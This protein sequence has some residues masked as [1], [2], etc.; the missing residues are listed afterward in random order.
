MKIGFSILSLFLILLSPRAQAQMFSCETTYMESCVGPKAHLKTAIESCELEMKAA[1]CDEWFKDRPQASGAKRTCDPIEVCPMPAKIT[2]LAESCADGVWNSSVDLVKGA[3]D[4]VV[5]S[6]K[7]SPEVKAREDYFKKCVSPECKIEMLG[8]YADLFTLE[9]IAGTKDTK[10]NP[11]DVQ[12][13]VYLNG[14]SSK[15]LYRMLQEKLR[16][17]AQNGNSSDLWIEPWSGNPAAPKRSVDDLVQEVMTASGM[18]NTA[19]YRPEKVYEARCYALASVLDPLAASVAILRIKK[20]SGLLHAT[21][22]KRIAK[23]VKRDEHVANNVMRGSTIDVEEFKKSTAGIWADKNLTDQ[24][25]AQAVF[26]K[27]YEMRT[28]NLDSYL[29]GHADKVIGDVQYVKGSKGQYNM[30]TQKILI[31]SDYVDVPVNHYLTLAH[32][33]EHVVQ[34]PERT[35]FITRHL[36]STLEQKLTKSERPPG[37]N[38]R[39]QAE[40]EA[41][42]SQWDF[43]QSVPQEVRDRSVEMIRS[44]SKIPQKVK[45]ASIADIQNANLSRADYLKAVAG[46]HGYT[47]YQMREQKKSAIGFSIMMQFAADGATDL[48][49]KSYEKELNDRRKE[50]ESKGILQPFSSDGKMFGTP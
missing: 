37:V 13:Q 27:Y 50:L 42:S 33:F 3:I 18:S 15:T 7:V 36:A 1:K 31:G 2:S 12:N 6:S 8:P 24:Q 11:D 45:E 21:D 5:G 22:Q 35:S 16:K 48:K 28:A 32:E 20:I 10:L 29:K 46:K 40:F 41:M 4:F 25:K 23:A 44:N 14:Y 9:E 39:L 34:Y 30:V 49:Q 17:R 38:S 26:S 43:L 47:T 19:C